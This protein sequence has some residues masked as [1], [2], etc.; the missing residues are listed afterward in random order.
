MN[1]I[2][3]WTSNNRGIVCF[4]AESYNR[5]GSRPLRARGAGS[6]FVCVRSRSVKRKDLICLVVRFWTSFNHKWS[7][8]P[9]WKHKLSS[10]SL[11]LFTLFIDYMKWTMLTISQ[12]RIEVV[13]RGPEPGGLLRAKFD[14]HALARERP[15]PGGLSFIRHRSRIT[16]F[17]TFFHKNIQFDSNVESARIAPCRR[18][19][20][21]GLSRRGAVWFV[22]YLNLF[23]LNYVV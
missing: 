22:N 18:S 14:R 12:S 3:D 6:Y 16:R 8:F 23:L 17:H 2:V 15:R 4:F 20:G 19:R 9:S 21:A 1:E 10:W 7:V 13:A 11:L 5:A